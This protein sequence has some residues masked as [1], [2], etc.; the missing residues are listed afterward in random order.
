MI[1]LFIALVIITV[2][3]W[4]LFGM[5]IRHGDGG[6]ILISSV[7]AIVFTIF[8]IISGCAI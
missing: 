4:I 1:I 2:G 5:N 7:T 6:A 8:S 3:T